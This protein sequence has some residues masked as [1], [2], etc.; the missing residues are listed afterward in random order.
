MKLDAKCNSTSNG[1]GKYLSAF[2]QSV[3]I[4][5]FRFV[6]VLAVVFY[7]PWYTGVVAV[8]RT[9]NYLK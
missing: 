8:S 2:I 5:I 1:K 6:K 9:M 4:A 7:S 3:I